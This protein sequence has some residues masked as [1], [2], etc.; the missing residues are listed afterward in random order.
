MMMTTRVN[1]TISGLMEAVPERVIVAYM[2]AFSEYNKGKHVEN[3]NRQLTIFVKVTHLGF[4]VMLVTWGAIDL[5][6]LVYTD[7]LVY[8]RADLGG[9]DD[10]LVVA[11]SLLDD[12]TVQRG[13][14]SGLGYA[15]VLTVTRLGSSTV[16]TLD[17]VDGRQGDGRARLGL[18]VMVVMVVVSVSVDLNAGIR[19]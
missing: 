1:D 10:M 9:L 8:S 18:V 11:D 7:S 19:V 2:G 16:P 13:V 3:E 17:V 4:V 6:R 5:D 15:D 14:D 12:G